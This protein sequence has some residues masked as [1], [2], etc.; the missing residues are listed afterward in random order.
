MSDDTKR[1]RGRPP[2][3]RTP[4]GPAARTRKPPEQVTS[5]QWGIRVPAGLDS[6]ARAAAAAAGLDL[7]SWVRQVCEQRLVREEGTP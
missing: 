7:A 3:V 1:G 2:G 4:H 6:G 5:A